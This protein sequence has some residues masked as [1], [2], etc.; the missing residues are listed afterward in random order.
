MCDFQGKRQAIVRQHHGTTF[1]SEALAVLDDRC[2]V[3]WGSCPSG[4]MSWKI[5]DFP[6]ENLG[7]SQKCEVDVMENHEK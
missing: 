7:F 6:M 5:W 4:F 2:L 3:H 1:Q